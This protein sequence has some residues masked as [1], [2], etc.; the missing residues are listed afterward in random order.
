MTESDHFVYSYIYFACIVVDNFHTY[1]RLSQIYNFSKL[2]IVKHISIHHLN[3]SSKGATTFSITTLCI[4][5]P[6]IRVL[7]TTFGITTLSITTHVHYNECRIL[8]S[9]AESHY[10]ECRYA[11]CRYVEC[12]YA[13]CRYVESCSITFRKVFKKN[14]PTKG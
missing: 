3:H 6:R 14:F 2:T 10:S 13:R 9:Y 1:N 11:E 7:F 5:T 8:F 12:R 4:M